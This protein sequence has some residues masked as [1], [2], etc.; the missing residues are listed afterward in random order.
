[1]LTQV[2]VSSAQAAMGLGIELSGALGKRTRYQVK[3]VAQMR[4]IV[5]TAS[6]RGDQGAANG[7]AGHT[8]A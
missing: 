3:E 5:T 8:I 6:E 1:M 7:N 4:L 2:H